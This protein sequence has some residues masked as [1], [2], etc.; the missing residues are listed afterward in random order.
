MY[1]C[2]NTTYHLSSAGGGSVPYRLNEADMQ[3]MDSD[4]CSAIWGNQYREDVHICITSV[5]Q[6]KGS[7]NVRLRLCITQKT[8]ICVLFLLLLLVL[9]EN[10]TSPSS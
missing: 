2:Y 1:D 7:C 4:E 9:L 5:N 8:T 3:I 10:K 6:D